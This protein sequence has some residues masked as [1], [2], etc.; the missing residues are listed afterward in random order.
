MADEER[1]G[2]ST[3]LRPHVEYY[4]EGLAKRD[5]FPEHLR[6]RFNQLA[7][8][9]YPENIINPLKSAAYQPTIV[10]YKHGRDK[11]SLPPIKKR[12]ELLKQA[13]PG[14]TLKVAFE[15][16]PPEQLQYIMHYLADMEYRKSGGVQNRK[17]T[18]SP[19]EYRSKLMSHHAEN[20]ALWMLENGFNVIPI[21][22]KQVKTWIQE[23]RA[24]YPVEEDFWGEREPV[25]REAFSAIKRDQYGLGVIAAER[26]DVIAVGFSHALKY[27]LLLQR[28]GE[29]SFYIMKDVINWE[30]DIQLW[31]RVHRT[32]K[33]QGALK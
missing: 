32:F 17:I 29:R 19:E 20:L 12:L 10:G 6:S 25:E 24:L 7:K 22:S 4:P 18:M 2:P 26:P 21:E 15:I 5:E 31:E 11:T 16:I 28:D 23:A 27:D 30:Q 14:K 9:I 1:L 3:I 13:N 33:A 8:G